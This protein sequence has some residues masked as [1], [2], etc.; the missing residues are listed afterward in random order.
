[1]V[2]GAPEAA[3]VGDELVLAV[4]VAVEVVPAGLRALFEAGAEDPGGIGAGAVE[5]G[6]SAVGPDADAAAAR[7][8]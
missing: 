6:V 1:V 8:A 3:G 7:E 5:A 2:V 4:G